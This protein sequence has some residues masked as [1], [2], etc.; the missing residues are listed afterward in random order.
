MA[1][2][3]VWLFSVGFCVLG[4]ISWFSTNTHAPP[5]IPTEHRSVPVS[6]QT[7]SWVEY[8]S[9][10]STGQENRT[11]LVHEYDQQ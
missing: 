1:L 4:F 9:T 8:C 2:S 3:F 7:W 11:M 5:Y 6:S 10:R